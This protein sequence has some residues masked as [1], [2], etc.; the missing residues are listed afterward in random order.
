MFFNCRIF[1]I[2]P[3]YLNVACML[4]H[5]SCVQLSVTLWTVALQAPLS[6]G[7]SRQEY[8]SGLPC[9]PAGDLPNPGTEPCLLHLFYWQ[10]GSLPLAPPA[11][12]VLILASVQFYCGQRIY[13]YYFS[14]YEFSKALYGPNM[15]HIGKTQ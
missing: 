13:L 8:W 4:S 10:A 3:D 15:V 1:G 14:P 5:F 9:P 2:H 7:L 11:K 12:P 6:I